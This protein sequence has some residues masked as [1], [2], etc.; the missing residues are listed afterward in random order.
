MTIFLIKC[1]NNGIAIH[2][3]IDGLF[4]HN[5]LIVGPLLSNMEHKRHRVLLLTSFRY[6]H[7]CLRN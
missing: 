7:K 6:Y 3:S 2:L 5:K 1:A 4:Q